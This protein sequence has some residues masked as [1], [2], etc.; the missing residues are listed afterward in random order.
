MQSANSGNH[1]DSVDQ[2]RQEAELEIHQLR[3]TVGAMRERMAVMQL[4]A[5]QRVQAA[6]AE[7]GD[8]ARQLRQQIGALREEMENLQASGDAAV[9]AALASRENDL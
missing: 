1:S 4:E 6:V 2:Q 7:A 5:D 3:Q 9:Q 8:E